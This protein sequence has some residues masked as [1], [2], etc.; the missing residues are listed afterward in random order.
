MSTETSNLAEARGREWELLERVRR[1]AALHPPVTEPE[2]E[3]TVITISREAGTSAHTVAERVIERL[4]PEWQLWDREIVDAVAESA[5][6]RA[7]LAATFDET[8]QS[9]QERVVRYLTNYWGF[10]PNKYYQHLVEVMVTLSRQGRKIIIGRGANFVL[11]HALN[12]R[13]SASETFRAQSIAQFEGLTS[14]TASNRM[15]MLD[16]ERSDFVHAFFGRDID[17]SRAYDITLRMDHIS[18]DTAAAAIAAAIG[19][20]ARG[21]CRPENVPAD[22]PPRNE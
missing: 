3:R 16:K 15:H 1:E 22:D 6:V 9:K 8:L 14:E 2:P 20:H 17:D 21:C 10:K 5:K 18:L 19:E 12:I 13:L 11:P 4:G 7:E